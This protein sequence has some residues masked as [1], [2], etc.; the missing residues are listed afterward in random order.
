M[1]FLGDFVIFEFSPFALCK[2]FLLPFYFLIQLELIKYKKA[3]K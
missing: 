1:I 3:S 2:P